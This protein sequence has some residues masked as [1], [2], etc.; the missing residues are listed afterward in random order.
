MIKLL[1]REFRPS[2]STIDAILNKAFDV[3]FPD[4]S[5]LLKIRSQD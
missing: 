2:S 1:P 5:F 3:Y 4:Y